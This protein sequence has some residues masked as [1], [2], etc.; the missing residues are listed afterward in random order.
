MALDYVRTDVPASIGESRSNN[1]R[2]IRLFSRTNFAHFCAVFNCILQ[3]KGKQLVMSFLAG[4]IFDGF[5][6]ITYDYISMD[7][8]VNFGYSRS[9]GSW[10][11]PEADFVSSER[12][13]RSL[14][15][16]AAELPCM[17]FT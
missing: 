4:G 17:R 8:H 14:S 2:I 1:G 13:Y 6:T 10:D 15:Q 11:I 9:N 3:P 12:I 16:K 5:F 7:V